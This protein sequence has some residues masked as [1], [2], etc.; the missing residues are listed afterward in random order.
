ME[1]FYCFKY[2]NVIV[3]DFLIRDKTN[4]KIIMALN[5]N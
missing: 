5:D 3:I 4:N 2:H 1:I